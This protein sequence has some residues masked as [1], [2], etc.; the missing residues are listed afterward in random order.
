MLS[1]ITSFLPSLPGWLTL[2]AN[3][4]DSLLQGEMFVSFLATPGKGPSPFLVCS[5]CLFAGC[6]SCCTFIL[7]T[8]FYNTILLMTNVLCDTGL[9][10][11]CG[12]SVLCNLLRVHVFLEAE[13]WETC[14][15][16][17]NSQNMTLEDMI[18]LGSQATLLVIIIPF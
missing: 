1:L 4:L 3:P 2:D 17:D 10:G 18:S 13:R 5:E 9:V 6:Y 11:A 12:I 14:T 15:T 8:I 7:R 16:L